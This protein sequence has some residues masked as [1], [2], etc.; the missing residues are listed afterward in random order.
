MSD[1]NM[2]IPRELARYYN[3]GPQREGEADVDF[4]YRVAGARYEDEGRGSENVITGLM[5]AA[6]FALHGKEYSTDPQRKVDDEFAAGTIVRFAK[7][8]PPPETILLMLDMFG[9]DR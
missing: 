4:R 6:A 5:G 1:V 7:H 3:L 9:R 2:N 8:D